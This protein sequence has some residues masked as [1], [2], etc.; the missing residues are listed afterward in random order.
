LVD[1]PGQILADAKVVAFDI[2]LFVPFDGRRIGINRNVGRIGGHARRL[3]EHWGVQGSGFGVQGVRD[4]GG[5][6]EG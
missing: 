1:P 5:K 6:S 3:Y 2:R 4:Q